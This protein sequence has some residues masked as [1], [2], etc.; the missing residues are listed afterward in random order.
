MV[1]VNHF[2]EYVKCS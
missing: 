2:L 1:A